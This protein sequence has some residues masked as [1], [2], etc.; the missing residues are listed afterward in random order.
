MQPSGMNG[1][2]SMQGGTTGQSGQ[3]G[4]QAGAGR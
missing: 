4:G 1:G 3:M 2:A